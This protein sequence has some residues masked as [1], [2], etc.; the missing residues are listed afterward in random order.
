[1][2]DDDMDDE[3]LLNALM[4][5]N[6]NLTDAFTTQHLA[7]KEEIDRIHDF[8][9]DH[10]TPEQ[11]R[12]GLINAL[13]VMGNLERHIRATTLLTKRDNPAGFLQ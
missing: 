7:V 10:M 13:A 2:T 3:E 9:V 4:A 1:M 12:S 5:A 6:N 11:R 8:L